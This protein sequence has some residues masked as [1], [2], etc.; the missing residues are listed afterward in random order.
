M[1][2][3][4]IAFQFLTI[5]PLPFTLQWRDER[6]IGRAMALFPLVGLALGG[7]LV[8]LDLLLAPRLPAGIVAALLL[9]ALAACTGALHLD[10]LADVC[11]GLAA[12]GNRERFL[13]IMK[14][15]RTG[16]VGV[17]GLVLLLLLKWQ[18]IVVLPPHLRWQGLLLA[19][20][21]GRFVMVAV[22]ALACQART[23][24]LGAACA[25]GAGWL[26]LALAFL[27]T[28]A[29][30]VALVGRSGMIILAAVTLLGYGIRVYFHRRLGGVTGDIIGCA[31]ELA[32]TCSLVLLTVGGMP[33]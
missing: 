19:P 9:I 29:I 2:L 17:V 11:D 13:A 6:E 7:M 25:A 14:D 4:F 20:T 18:A 22:A 33:S 10:G 32:E 1:R 5:I 31:G 23:D 15:S 27:L 21:L 3:F 16:A 28:G 8:G 30:T 12:R 24:G 26:Q